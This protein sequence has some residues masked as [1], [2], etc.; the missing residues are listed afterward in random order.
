MK[1]AMA[2]AWWRTNQRRLLADNIATAPEGG[3]VQKIL[4]GLRL[5]DMPFVYDDDLMQVAV[6]K[7]PCYR[8]ARREGR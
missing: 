1:R 3:A 2:R 5:S 7:S 4:K 6:G 8:W